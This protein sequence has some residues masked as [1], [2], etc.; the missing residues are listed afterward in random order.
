MSG[1]DI[2][3]RGMKIA[4]GTAGGALGG[5]AFIALAVALATPTVEQWEGTRTDPYRDMIGIWTVCTGETR[6]AMRRYTPAQCQLMLDRA[7]TS[8]FAPGVL[9]AVP[10]LRDHPHQF[11]ASISL[12]YNIGVSAFA[13]STVAKRFNAGDW[14]GGCEAFLAWHFAGGKAVTGLRNRRRDERVLCLSGL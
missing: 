10:A 3:G 14:R 7:L 2:G 13:R 4:A 9:K 1:P 12:S 6:V 11:A 5:G 8:E